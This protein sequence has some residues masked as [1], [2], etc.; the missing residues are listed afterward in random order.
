MGIKFELCNKI[1]LFFTDYQCGYPYICEKQKV[2]KRDLFEYLFEKLLVF[3][4]SS[5]ISTLIIIVW[6]CANGK[7]ELPFWK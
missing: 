6:F 7:L 2:M 3:L 1:V 5:A 4:I